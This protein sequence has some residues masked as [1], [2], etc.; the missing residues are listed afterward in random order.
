M[1]LRG[2]RRRRL[3]ALTALL[4]AVIA[5]VLASTGPGSHA[6]RY[7]PAGG[8]ATAPRAPT[9][10]LHVAAAPAWHPA[11]AA[12]RAAAR[13][14]LAAQVA[15]LFLVTVNGN[16]AAAGARLAGRGWGGVVLAHANAASPAAA[17]RA[18]R[19]AADRAHRRQSASHH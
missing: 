6:P 1:S 8:R 9:P 14:P 16:S 17:A 11:P 18:H 3:I 15:Q 2:H 13:L 7:L 12:V 5:A 19:S 10:A 4:V